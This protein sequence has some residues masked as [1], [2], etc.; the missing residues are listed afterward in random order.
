[1]RRIASGSGSTLLPVRGTEDVPQ[2]LIPNPF[3]RKTLTA[4]NDGCRHLERFGSGQYKKRI[5]GGS[6]SV[7][8]EGIQDELDSICASSKIY[9]L[10][11]P[12]MGAKRTCSMMAS[13]TLST[14][15]WSPHPTQSIQ[16]CTVLG[17]STWRSTWHSF[18]L[19]GWNRSV[20]S[21]IHARRWFPTPRGPEKDRH[22]LTFA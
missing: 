11:L 3:E 6:S 9:T 22:V 14:P 21:Q 17:S 7:L 18:S 15:V 1:M 12:I 13:R 4:R 8:K 2:I 16:E 20:L 10:R 19:F 5:R